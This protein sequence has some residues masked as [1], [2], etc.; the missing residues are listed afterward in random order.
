MK[1]PIAKLIKFLFTSTCIFLSFI[2]TGCENNEQVIAIKKNI[3]PLN[4]SN[5]S[6]TITF[7]QEN[8]SVFLEAHV[9]G[10]KPGTKAI[11]V[12]EFGDCSSDDGLSTGG[13][14]N[15]TNTKS[16]NETCDAP[17]VDRILISRNTSSS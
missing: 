7:T 5:I 8:D 17:K 10:L 14:W 12:H 3:K 16:Q 4:N 15:P 13:H 1:T 9:F 11:H 6:G 2:T